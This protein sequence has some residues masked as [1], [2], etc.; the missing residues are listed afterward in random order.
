MA[1]QGD[2]VRVAAER[3][4]VLPQPVEAG[5][6]VHQAEVALRAA[7]RPRFQEAWEKGKNNRDRV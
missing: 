6:E 3:G 1:H 4:Q 2:P 7:L 5:D